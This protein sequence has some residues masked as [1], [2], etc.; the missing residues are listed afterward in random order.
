[1]AEP[2]IRACEQHPM[3]APMFAQFC[4]CGQQP[5]LV[6]RSV[7]PQQAPWHA[8]PCGQQ[9]PAPAQSWS[10][11]QQP[12]SQHFSEESQQCVARQSDEPAGQSGTQAQFS[13]SRTKPAGQSGTHWLPQQSSPSAQQRRSHSSRS[14]PGGC[15]GP[16]S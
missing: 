6:H 7:S 16:H 8:R 14:E 9:I 2:Q 13:N 12:P 4:P 15:S 1:L 3:V 10:A 5:Q 11:G